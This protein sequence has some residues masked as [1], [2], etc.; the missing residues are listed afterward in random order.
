MLYCIY[1]DNGLHKPCNIRN[2]RTH[3]TRLHSIIVMSGYVTLRQPHQLRV[4]GILKGIF[5]EKNL[6]VWGTSLFFYKLFPLSFGKLLSI[7]G[8]GE[9][10][11]FSLRTNMLQIGPKNVFWGKKICFW[12]KISDLRPSVT[13][14]F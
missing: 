13:G 12:W 14:V 3:L 6:L 8:G 4:N 1:L 10:T 5:H 11:R 2:D 7:N 9:K